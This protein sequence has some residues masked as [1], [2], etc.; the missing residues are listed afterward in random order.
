MKKIF[1]LITV[2]SLL[3][4]LAAVPARA[5]PYAEYP[6]VYED[7]EE[8]GDIHA[9]ASN[10]SISRATEGVAGTKGA[11][12]I[13]VNNNYGTAKFPL[14]VKKGTTYR[15][16]AWVKMAGDIPADK[17]LHFIFYMHEKL[18]D[19]TPAESASCFKDIIV[20]DVDYSKEY[21]TYVETT[22]AYEG[23]GRLNG[24]DVETCDGDATVEI[25]IGN[26]TL[27]TTNN[28]PIDYY[29]DDLIV[30]PVTTEEEEPL[31]DT[32]VGLKNGNF[33]SGFDTSAWISQNCTVTET[34]GANGTKTGVKVT[35]TGTYGQIKQR[36]DIGFNK[37]YRISVYAKAGDAATVGK[38]FKLI[39]DRKDGKTDDSLTTNYVMLPSAAASSQP[40][41]L[42]LTEEWQ[43][44]EI[45]YKANTA[46]FETN[47]PYIYPR[48]GSGT[49]MECY[50]LD[51]WEVEEL[52]GLVYNGG[53][54]DGAAGWSKAGVTVQS[55]D[56]PA[57]AQGNGIRVTETANYAQFAQGLDLQA[58][59][60]YEISFWARGERWAS[61]TEEIEFQPVLDRY[62]AN[63]ED[64]ADA[65]YEY[66]SLD[67]GA[68][69]VL[70]KEW[71][72]YTFTYTAD[73]QTTR[74]RTPLFYLNIGNGKQKAVY[75]LADVQVA[76]LDPAEP[77]EPDQPA[78]EPVVSGLAI[79]GKPVEN[80]TLTLTYD[81]DGPRPATGL[82]KI[83]KSYQNKYV[84]LGGRQLSE[85][86]VAYTLT[87]ADVGSFVKFSLMPLDQDGNLGRIKTC[88][89]AEV[90]RALHIAPAFIAGLDAA[91]IS[92]RVRVVNNDQEQDI[93]VMLA[94]FDS[95]N[96][97]IGIVDA[98]QNVEFE[99]ETEI[100]LSIDNT[101]DVHAARLFIWGG[102]SK[103]DTDMRS[104]TA[105]IS[106]ER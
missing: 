5:K 18:P 65:M 53:F 25:R 2:F 6:W 3:A 66:L 52:P 99:E 21:Y 40:A 35:S 15:V 84:S 10:A 80:H 47:R 78:K 85:E 106:L 81:Y 91:Q 17:N 37:A 94:V 92:G 70:T 60:T 67:D 83:M 31:P 4:G 41:A 20:R 74:Y 32:S 97:L 100:A 23:T 44:L 50:C 16:S 27:A 42:I 95:D 56:G 98:F 69:P 29:L 82:V 59:K 77:D 34:E 101:P 8:A 90:T 79:D 87:S 22:F 72:K 1:S 63:S 86:P 58:G 36:T 30:E 88:E 11:A 96:A 49:N 68:V 13:T 33:E 39:I 73:I 64:D 93:V 7:F 43:K 19:G 14:Q 46:T 12:R 28:N 24:K 9:T 55:A 62:A 105:G 45:I 54:A 57:E 48:V 103:L 104:L 26:G 75:D 38:E 51:E 76:D 89:T 61:G 102:R 71:Q